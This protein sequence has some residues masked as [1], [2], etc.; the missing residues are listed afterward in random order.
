[1]TEKRRIIHSWH[2]K[3]RASPPTHLSSDAHAA[4]TAATTERSRGSAMCARRG[5]RRHG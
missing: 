1:M 5:G 4:T 3:G 2:R